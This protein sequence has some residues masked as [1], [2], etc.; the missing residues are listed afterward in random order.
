MFW[1]SFL[2]DRAAFNRS[3]CKRAPK[4]NQRIPKLPNPVELGILLVGDPA[5]LTRFLEQGLTCRSFEVI[6]PGRKK[7]S[8][9][10]TLNKCDAK[11]GCCKILS[12][13]KTIASF[14]KELYG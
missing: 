1:G 4:V 2:L 6:A 7:L 5:A 13:R 12:V 14:L 3:F 10:E 8:S 11:N 9:Q